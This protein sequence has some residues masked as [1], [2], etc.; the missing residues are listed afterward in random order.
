[1]LFRS[2]YRQSQREFVEIL[3]AVRDG[4]ADAEVIAAL[5]RRFIPGFNPQESEGYIR[6]TTHNH[7]ADEINAARLAANPDEPR[8]FTAQ[9]TSVVQGQPQEKPL[10]RPCHYGKR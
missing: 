3:N 7:L 5:N 2:V 6:L 8:T 1:M 4:R 9:Q 10:V